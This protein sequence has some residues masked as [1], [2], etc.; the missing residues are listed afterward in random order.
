VSID[1]IILVYV[2]LPGQCISLEQLEVCRHQNWNLIFHIFFYRI[3]RFIHWKLHSGSKMPAIEN[4]GK[5][6]QGILE[7]VQQ[8]L[9]Y[10]TSTLAR[11]GF[12][13]VELVEM[14]SNVATDCN[15]IETNFFFN[16]LNS[17]TES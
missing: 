1:K 3:M 10:Q 5:Y 12:Q 14:V 9:I 11:L 15:E 17:I 13:S 6:L 8:V 2:F 4:Q 7:K 16:S